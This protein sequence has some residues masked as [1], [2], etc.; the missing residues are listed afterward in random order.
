[1]FIDFPNNELFHIKHALD[2][3]PNPN[4]FDMH[5]HSHYELLIFLSGDITY[6]VEGNSYKPSPKDI[7]LFDIAETHKVVVNADIPYERTVIQLDKN[8]LSLFTDENLLIECF[9]NR[10]LGEANIIH[11]EDFSDSLFEKCIK[12][13]QKK[14]ISK[15]EA[16]SF[17]LPLINEIS[18]VVQN[19]NITEENKQL[20]SKIVNY[21]NDNIFKNISPND[22]AKHFYISRTSLY[23]IFRET[24]GT[25]IH[26][27][28]NVKRLISAQELLSHGNKPTSVYLQCGFNDYTTFYRAYKTK[29]GIAPKNTELKP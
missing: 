22:I 24:T 3:H 6:L 20:P 2:V 4:A 16:I 12:R 27:Y 26:D 21:I 29:F 5:A 8:L 7:L 13:L 19:K 14:N 11:P 23:N 18:K 1:M 9:S 25:S 10:P 28:I 17:L 15:T